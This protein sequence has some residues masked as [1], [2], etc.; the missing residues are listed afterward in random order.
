MNRWGKVTLCILLIAILL[1]GC[2]K[3]PPTPSATPQQPTIAPTPTATVTPTHSP[4][5]EER[6]TATATVEP[7]LT[8]ASIL[9]DLPPVA[10]GLQGLD[11][12]TFYEESYK[13][14]GLRYPEYI[15]TLGLSEALGVRKDQLNNMSDAYI[16]ETQELEKA[17][18]ALLKTYDRTTLTPEQQLSYDVYVWYL[19]DKI[20]G[21]EFMYYD[22]VILPGVIGYQDTLVQFFTDLYPLTNKQDAEDY[23]TCLS[24]VETQMKQVVDGLERRAEIGVVLPRGIIQWMGNNLRK[25]ADSDAD[26]TPFYTAFEEKLNT[27]DNVSA[28]D[29][30]ALLKAAEDAIEKSVLPGF[31]ALADLVEKQQRTATDA[32]GVSKFPDGEAYYAYLLRHYTTTDLTAD[33]IHEL[34][35][36]DL[37]RIHAEMRALFDQLGYPQDESLPNLYNRVA[38]ESGFLQGQAILREYEAII[39][40]VKAD[41]APVFDLQPKADVIVIGVPSGGYYLAPAVD[42]S[43][44]GAF[45][46]SN[47]GS[48]PR[49]GMRTLAYHEAIPGHHQQIAIAQELPLPFF[50]KDMGFT[51][52][53]EGWA[54]YA[55]R[56]AWELGVYEDDIY[57]DLGRLQAEAFR[58]TR[59]VVD[60]GIHVKGWTYTQA[61]DYMLQ[62]TGMSRGAVESQ[63][64]RYITWP[65][66]ATA[67]KVGM[68]EILEQRQ[69]AMDALGDDF[70]LKAFHNVVLGNGS[71]PLELLE[72]LVDDYI[73]AAQ[74]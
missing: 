16:R 26:E 29:K 37:I 3:T 19:E 21:H 73:A 71:V 36:Q 48:E 70:D 68:L 15:T 13:R 27:L 9:V 31:D 54:L 22:Y 8:S 43:R 6:A 67:Y 51:G 46:A 20:R 61:V 11:I 10:D 52:Y 55:E 33:E 2:Q 28:A 42:G 14:L 49:S 17:V 47:T 38:K 64:W 34:G 58:A 45:Y 35:Q 44:P 30:K 60:T 1:T 57:G 65:G 72:V 39:E 74:D 69:R 40:A 25:M 59:L 5:V 32:I 23:V 62:N 41:I 50:R 63:I 18:L 7:S 56:L 24:Q 66:Q 12:D 53:V 4:Q